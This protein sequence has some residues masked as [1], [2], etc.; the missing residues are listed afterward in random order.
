MGERHWRFC[1]RCKKEL[2]EKDSYSYKFTRKAWM[3]TRV[4]EYDFCRKCADEVFL[5]MDGEKVVE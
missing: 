3:T 1:D 4:R 5:F 2:G